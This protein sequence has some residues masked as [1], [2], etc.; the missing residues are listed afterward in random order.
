MQLESTLLSVDH[1]ATNTAVD[2]FHAGRDRIPTQCYVKY[3]PVDDVLLVGGGYRTI[4]VSDTARGSAY[5]TETVL[6]TRRA[7]PRLRARCRRRSEPRP[8][9]VADPDAVAAHVFLEHFLDQR[10]VD[11]HLGDQSR[12]N[13]LD[14]RSGLA[15]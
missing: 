5:S 11:S 14:A 13:A 15:P 12:G 1:A 9:L 6:K 4:P 10:G 7:Q 2:H 8:R 3:P